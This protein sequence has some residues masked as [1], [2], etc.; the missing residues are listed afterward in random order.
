MADIILRVRHEKGFSRVTVNSKDSVR[1]LKEKICALV[2]SSS[3]NDVSIFF[4]KTMNYN[5]QLMA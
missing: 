5:S 3:T 2:G 1:V 4:D